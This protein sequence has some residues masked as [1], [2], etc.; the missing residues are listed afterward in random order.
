[1][2]ELGRR[3]LRKWKN[4]GLSETFDSGWEIIYRK[5]FLKRHVSPEIIRISPYSFLNRNELHE[6][7]PTPW[8][9]KAKNTPAKIPKK[10][11][12]KPEKR[13]SQVEKYDI[14]QSFVSEIDGGVVIGPA[15]IGFSDGKL[16]GDTI[17]PP[18]LLE[19]RME[20]AISRTIATH[21]LRWGYKSFISG[22]EPWGDL[23]KLDIACPVIPL[24]ENY[25]HWLVECIPKLRGLEK[26]SERT[27]NEPVLIIPPDL[28]SWAGELL[29]IMGVDQSQCVE[30]TEKGYRTDQL[31]VPSY[32]EPTA[33]EC[34]WLRRNAV[35]S[36]DSESDTRDRVYIS[37][38]NATRRQ[39]TNEEELMDA[40]RPLGFDSYVLEEMSVEA[41]IKLFSQAEIV[42]GPHGAGFANTIFSNDTHVIEIFGDRLK[43]TFYRL[44][45]IVGLEYDHVK[46]DDRGG[47]IEVDPEKVVKQIV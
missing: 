45:T 21:G 28:P 2:N 9:E 42:V 25:Y 14:S 11:W 1:M 15:G 26:Y 8:T 6:T 18:S 35:Q 17:A 27:G 36:V 3:A 23:P 22:K 40:L 20:V 46:G 5:K 30:F 10:K 31:V 34:D 37:R 44:A 38:Q 47:D 13:I 4:D 33:N 16:I 29:S 32:P 39:L 7:Y 24:W 12:I 19:N 41:Q 43:T